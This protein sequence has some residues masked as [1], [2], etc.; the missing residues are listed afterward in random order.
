MLADLRVELHLLCHAFRMDVDDEERT[1]FS[2]DNLTHY[3]RLYNAPKA[4]Y[5][6]T[7]GAKKVDECLEPM[8]ET[9]TVEGDMIVGKL[10]QDTEFD[11]LMEQVDTARQERTDRI[12]AGDEGAKLK[13]KALPRRE[14]QQKGQRYSNVG[15]Y[16]DQQK[17]GFQR[18]DG[19]NRDDNYQQRYP[20]FRGDDRDDRRHDEYR[21]R[22]DGDREDA[23]SG[24]RGGKGPNTPQQHSM[25]SRPHTS[26]Q[27]GFN[28]SSGMGSYN[29]G[30]SSFPSSK[31]GNSFG[32][33][34]SFGKGGRDDYSMRPLP[35]NV[36]GVK[37]TMPPSAGGNNMYQSGP[38]RFQGNQGGR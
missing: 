18:R 36:G 7:Y 13:F 15:G 17:G 26:P 37:R 28:Q 30:G 14:A 3:Y 2:A 23:Q 1:K 24:Y 8:S 29:K 16:R 5:V 34:P 20:S 27:G 33:R 9:V 22:D 11:V 10:D 19:F 32:N 12:G 25:H 21:R 6:A 4:F 31:G 38:K 35:G